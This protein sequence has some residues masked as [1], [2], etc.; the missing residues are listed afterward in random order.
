MLAE[1]LLH[2]N[3]LY[4]HMTTFY[5]RFCGIHTFLSLLEVM[6]VQ[7]LPLLVLLFLVIMIMRRGWIM[8]FHCVL[9][10]MRMGVLFGT[11][12]VYQ[13]RPWSYWRSTLRNLPVAVQLARSALWRQHIWR[14]RVLV[15]GGM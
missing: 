4:C 15:R 10:A 8:K 11:M 3:T 2:V 13:R 14:G 5:E 12:R 7:A 1:L 9:R 6:F